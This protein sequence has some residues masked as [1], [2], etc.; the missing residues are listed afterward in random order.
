MAVIITGAYFDMNSIGDRAAAWDIVECGLDHTTDIRDV[1]NFGSAGW[2][3]SL[4]SLQGATVRVSVKDANALLD[5]LWALRSGS[6]GNA[7]T[8]E[9][10]ETNAAVSA[11]NPSFTGS[12]LI[13]ALSPVSVRVGEEHANQYTFTVTG[14]VTRNTT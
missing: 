9:I 4:A 5:D 7:V 10:R 11:T 12:C 3:E 2:K 6:T 8:F 1:T 13:G 14:A